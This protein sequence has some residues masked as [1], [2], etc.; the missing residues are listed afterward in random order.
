MTKFLIDTN[1]LIDA[2]DSFY[3]FDI[4][5]GFWNAIARHH[6]SDEVFSIDRIRGELLDGNDSLV[7]WAKN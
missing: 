1:S 6:A 2:K 3:A 5:P 7:R 4:C